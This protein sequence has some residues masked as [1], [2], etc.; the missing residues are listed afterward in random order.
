MLSR[1]QL[2]ATVW[3]VAHQAPMSISLQARILERVVIPFSR[4]SSWSRNQ[5]CISFISYTAG[6]F[7]TI[8]P[9]GK[10]SGDFQISL[11]KILTPKQK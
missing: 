9:L 1:V 7:F 6:G 2:F 4:G 3:T 11:L 8:A 5:T 10:P